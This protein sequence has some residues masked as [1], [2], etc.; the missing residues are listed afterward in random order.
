MFLT[1]LLYLLS[2]K[3]IFCFSSG[4]KIS[5]YNDNMNIFKSR[6]LRFLNENK[7]DDRNATFFLTNRVRNLV[8]KE[9]RAFLNRTEN[10]SQQCIDLLYTCYI[11]DN[12]TNIE[13]EEEDEDIDNINNDPISNFFIT[14]LFDGATKHKN[15]LSK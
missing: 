6:K 8:R 3:L 4:Q 15:D 11:H 2:L 12:K 13:I 10:V 9:L 7:D 1:Y 14:K 5:Q